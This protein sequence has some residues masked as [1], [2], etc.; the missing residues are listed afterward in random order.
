MLLLE[1]CAFF[2]GLAFFDGSTV[3]PVLLSRLHASDTVIGFTRLMQSVGYSLPALFAAHW[4]HGRAYHKRYL[5]LTAGIS[6]AGLLFVPAI[7]LAWGATRPQLALVGLLV[8]TSIFSLMD[9]ASAVSWLDIVAKAIPPRARGRLFGMMQ[10]LMGL[11]A[12]VCGAIVARIL[13][14]RGLPF[15]RNFALLGALWC[16]CAWLSE[17]ALAFVREPKGDLPDEDEK[18]AFN[19]YVRRVGP[20]LR[21]YP[22]VA[23]LVLYR[24]LLDGSGMAGPFYV[25][26]ARN[27]LH[28][29]LRMVGVYVVVQNVGRL[30]TGPVWGWVSDRHGAVTGLRIIT[31]A[32]VLM[33]M[34]ALAASSAGMWTLPIV[35]FLM[36]GA[37]DG[38]W[39]LTS[40]VLLES[41]SPA[42]RPFAV[43]VSSLLL[44]P[45]ALYGLAGGLLAQY[46]SYT[47]VFLGSLVFALAGAIAVLG[48]TGPPR[49]E[50][51]GGQ[52]DL[53]QG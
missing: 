34:A 15:P 2:A 10:T 52:I 43:G 30:V 35:F 21:R 18:P 27:D 40:N 42:E 36:G 25:L 4:I 29:S 13:Q 47:G 38:L 19:A 48:I 32:V 51:T 45:T 50:Q 3:L 5:L 22:R 12:M 53:L 23:R 7:L 20:M 41:T 6:R 1:A 28:V 17:L 31:A 8:F 26:Y 33:P 37:Q 16:A 49:A 11:L 14:S 24:L 9:G 46:T 44:A 39:M